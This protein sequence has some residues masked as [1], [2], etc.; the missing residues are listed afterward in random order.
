MTN[1]ID[2]GLVDG[3]LIVT[4]DD[5]ADIAKYSNDGVVSEVKVELDAI[6]GFEGYSDIVG[7]QVDYENNKFTRL[8]AAKGLEA[9]NDFDS[10]PMYGGM[11]RCNVNDDGE[12]TA[13][14]GDDSFVEDDTNL[15]VMVYVP[16]FYYK[17]L[18]LKLEK[19]EDGVGYH[20]RKANYYIS[21]K[22]YYGFKLHPAFYNEQGDEVDYFLYSAYEGLIEFDANSKIKQIQS[23]SAEKVPLEDLYNY[24]ALIKA[25]S[26]LKIKT[27][28]EICV[29]RGIGWHCETIQ[30]LSALQF[31]MMIEYGTMNLQSVLGNGVSQTTG[32]IF[33]FYY[34]AIPGSTSFLGNKSGEANKTIFFIYNNS[35][36]NWHIERIT[37]SVSYRGVE[38]PYG[39]LNRLIQG[40]YLFLDENS[41]LF[42]GICD[43]FI[44]DFIDENR[45]NY[46]KADFIISQDTGYISAFGYNDKNYD[47]LFFPSEVQGTNELPVGDYNKSCYGSAKQ[48]ISIGCPFSKNNGSQFGMFC[49]SE[50]S[51]FTGINERNKGC[52]L[53]YLPQN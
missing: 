8:G 10:F 32:G 53:I 19:I 12:I 49:Y 31:L 23:V 21:N 30:A 46:G 36:K 5:I 3:Q 11:K 22:Q 16:K 50:Y 45:A 34:S 39:N 25:T 42:I 6:N 27:A 37:K 18:P 38:N 17:V 29:A 13:W 40:A 20:I 4:E 33:D 24:Y 26:S 9:G 51:Y 52:R 35:D 48:S 44:Y 47:W 15:Q 2:L 41:E 43:N 7:L 14:Y 28:E 1:R